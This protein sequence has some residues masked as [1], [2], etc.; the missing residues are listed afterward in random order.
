VRGEQSASQT[1]PRWGQRG[2]ARRRLSCSGGFGGIGVP[3][4]RAVDLLVASRPREVRL[5]AA[6][7]SEGSAWL[8]VSK[9]TTAA[10]P[11]S[12]TVKLPTS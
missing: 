4:E 1:K 10:Q 5:S 8:E 2:L 9:C 7:P 12:A 6:C 3:P 11:A